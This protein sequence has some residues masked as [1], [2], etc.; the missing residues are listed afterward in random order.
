VSSATGA[1]CLDI[2]KDAWSPA[3]TIKTALLSVQV[4]LTVPEPD[5]PQDAVVAN[6]FK[7]N[8]AEYN[9]TARAWTEMHAGGTCGSG[10][11]GSEAGHSQGPSEPAPPSAQVRSTTT[12]HMSRLAY[13]LV[14]HSHRHRTN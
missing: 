2:L 7:A 14:R 12:M 6:M 5:D 4:L 9:A 1:I 3:L 13:P 8:I 11:G 10:V